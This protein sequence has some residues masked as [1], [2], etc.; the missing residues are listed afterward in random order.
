M[1]PAHK[2]FNSPPSTL[3][4][5]RGFSLVELLVVI[6]IMAILLT[7]GVASYNNFTKSSNLDGASKLFKAHLRLAQN[8]ALSGERIKNADGTEACVGTFNGYYVTLA[9]NATSYELGQYCST[10]GV[11]QRTPTSPI[12][13]PTE[14]TIQNLSLSSPV[15]ILFQS[16]R[17]VTFYSCA[18]APCFNSPAAV[19]A[20]DFKVSS[21]S[22]RSISISSDGKIQ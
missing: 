8:F 20:V 11:T 21:G 13:L 3:N 1:K 4:Y 9:N 7:I 22:T 14:I 15:T 16:V 10:S 2:T 12:N 17:G 18:P 6:A 5:Q 19:S